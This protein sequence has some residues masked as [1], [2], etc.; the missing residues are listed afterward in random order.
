MTAKLE[1]RMEGIAFGF[2]YCTHTRCSA[3][4]DYFRLNSFQLHIAFSYIAYFSALLS[5]YAP[6]PRHFG[7]APQSPKRCSPVIVG[8]PRNPSF[9]RHCGPD[10]QSSPLPSLRA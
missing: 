3:T 2:N 6:F 8:S 9:P 1:K 10:P 4:C 7:P 5:C